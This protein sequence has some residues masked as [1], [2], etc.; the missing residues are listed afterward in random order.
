[1]T[2][3]FV[4]PTLAIPLRDVST[5]PSVVMTIMFVPMIGVHRTLDANLPLLIVTM[6]INVLPNHAILY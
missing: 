1:M 4:P 6:A 5:P 2:Q 3:A